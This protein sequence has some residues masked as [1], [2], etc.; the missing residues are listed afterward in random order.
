MPR[1][2]QRNCC[3]V[4]AD[5]G[6][7]LSPQSVPVTPAP[8][9]IARR[10]ALISWLE[11]IE[12]SIGRACCGW[13]AVHSSS[14]TR[15]GKLCGRVVGGDVSRPQQQ[16]IAA[17]ALLYHLAAFEFKGNRGGLAA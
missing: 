9:S 5:E 6:C 3:G 8:A 15:A 1:S 4:L 11:R 2:S 10:G 12:A 13:C 14:E 16:A 7:R 17:I